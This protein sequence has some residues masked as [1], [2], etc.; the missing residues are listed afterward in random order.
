MSG[1]NHLPK[2]LFSY[3]HCPV[4]YSLNVGSDYSPNLME[5]K[6]FPNVALSA[7]A[8]HPNISRCFLPT[9]QVQII[10]LIPS[11]VEACSAPWLMF[12]LF[13][14]Y[15]LLFFA[16]DWTVFMDSHQT[17]SFPKSHHYLLYDPLPILQDQCESCLI[18]EGFVNLPSTHWP[19]FFELQI[20]LSLVNVLFLK[21]F[22]YCFVLVVVV[23]CFQNEDDCWV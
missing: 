22:M 4:L 1:K 21:W 6:A 19:R 12:W 17:P 14:K 13:P 15:I 16:V 7:P 18:Q 11:H 3:C 5:L 10:F 23:L 20:H 8:T 2:I 9:S